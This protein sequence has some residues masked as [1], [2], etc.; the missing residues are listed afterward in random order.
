MRGTRKYRHIIETPDPGK[1]ELAGYEATLPITEK[2]NPI[3]RE[4]DKADPAL[5]VQL[6]KECDAEIFQEEDGALINYQ[7]LYSESVLKTIA[8]IAKQVQ[9]ILKEPDDGLIVLSGCGNSGR[10]AM[11]LSNSFNKLLKGLH[12][13]PCYTYIISG[14]DR[15]L[16]SAQEAPEDNPLLGAAELEK[17]CA[18]KKKVAFIGI[19]CGL[20]APFIAGQLDFCMNNLDI[21]LP[22]LVGFNPVSMARNDRIEGWHS[23]FRQVAERMQKLQEMQKAL[24]LNPAV[25]PEGIS[26]SSRM[27]GGSATK[28]LLE[29]LFLVAHKADCNVEVTEKCLLEILR[30]YERAHKVTYSQSKKIASLVKQAAT[31]LQKKGH[32]YLLGWQTLG[33]MG[34]MEAVGCIPAFGADYRD[35][36]G[37]IA[38]GYNGMV[39]KEGDLTALGAEFAIS[40]EDFMK[41]ILPSLSEMDTVLFIFTLDDELPEIEKLAA[42]VKEKTSNFH[43][44]SHATAGQYLP[45]STK[46]LFP[47][48]I[49]ITWPILFLE[50][51]GNFIQSFQRELST[52]W[53][54]NTIS[55]GAHVLKGKIYRNYM[56]DFKVSNT[57]WFQRAVSVMQRLTE[58]PQPRCIET[59]LQS[60]Y[61]PE[62]LTDQ[63]RSFPISKHV[64]AASVKDK[65]LPVAIVSLLRSC[66]VHEAKT[67]LDAFP[68]IRAAIE[69]SIS[70][71]GR[72]RG[73]ETS[74]AAGQNK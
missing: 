71:P 40:H 16:V 42:L 10:M 39:N 61:G 32:L 17:V 31:S 24:I 4:I 63:I 36:R 59:L 37:F 21:F 22:V 7:R 46:K 8:D 41:N 68:S 29:T 27:K 69:A 1:W 53:I 62:M 20:S 72:K 3:T 67:R 60:I 13:K 51:E 73:A 2:S 50:Y 64:E 34:M 15:S 18:G 74:E 19:S 65:V 11:L 5:L 30:T 33:I 57:K 49:N 52:K 44:V 35:F 45:T 14:G 66:T 26:G 70:A 12:R 38:G 43:A 54:L 56:I 48:I 6:L 47:N 55:T 28:I 23:T 25:G 58:Q 9:E